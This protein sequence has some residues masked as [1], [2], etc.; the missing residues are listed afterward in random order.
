MKMIMLTAQ[1]GRSVAVNPAMVS[2]VHEDEY[3]DFD[4]DAYVV[5]TQVKMVD[6]YV[7]VKEDVKTVVKRLTEESEE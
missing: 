6:G 4:G 2:A 3:Y 7:Y 1:N 5:A